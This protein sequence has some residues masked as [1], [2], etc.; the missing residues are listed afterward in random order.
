MQL[1]FDLGFSASQAMFQYK[2]LCFEILL[3]TLN[4]D[5]SECVSILLSCSNI[6]VQSKFAN[7]RAV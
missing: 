7:C 5:M 1:V 2:L 4:H 6:F 3:S